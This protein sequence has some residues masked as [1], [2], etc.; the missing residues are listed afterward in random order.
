MYRLSALM[1]GLSVWLPVL[2]AAQA[3]PA[4]QMAQKMESTCTGF[5]HGPSLIAQQ[6]L[7]R[8]GW[9]REV[10]KMIAWGAKV[11][12]A[13]KDALIDYLT[14]TFNSSRPRPATSRVVP[15]GRGM[16][17]FQI[18]CMS[19]HDDSAIAVLKLDRG[20]WV[21]QVDRMIHW[22]A[23][24]PSARKNELIEYLVANFGR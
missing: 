21:R 8:A 3:Q 19:C 5:C 22:G 10:D 24:V 17:V 14:R 18:S 2:A 9:T 15:E 11:A 4:A 20:G 13:D 23:Y 7:G 12:D 1:I 16:D 6:R